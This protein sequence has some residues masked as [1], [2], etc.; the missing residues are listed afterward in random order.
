MREQRLAAADSESLRHAAER[1]QSTS[2][3]TA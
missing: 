1:A 2:D 3:D